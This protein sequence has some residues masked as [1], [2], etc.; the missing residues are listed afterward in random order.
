M[1]FDDDAL[2]RYDCAKGWCT[3]CPIYSPIEAETNVTVDAPLI[4]FQLYEK[5]FKCN[6]HDALKIGEKECPKCERRKQK[7]E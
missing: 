6:I 3:E 4:A 2:P 5:Q 7:N 1:Q